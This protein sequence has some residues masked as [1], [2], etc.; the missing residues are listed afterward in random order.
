MSYCSGRPGSSTDLAAFQ[1]GRMNNGEPQALPVSP[2]M[3]MMQIL[4]P[5]AMAV[6]A[7]HV[8]AKLALADLVAGASGAKSSAEI[9]SKQFLRERTRT[10]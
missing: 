7:I 8:A 5:G 3:Q 9:S 1:E 10:C 4:W 2:S 6:Q